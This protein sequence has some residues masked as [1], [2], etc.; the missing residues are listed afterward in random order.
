M[1][2]IRNILYSIEKY[3]YVRIQ[4]TFIKKYKIQTVINSVFIKDFALLL[5]YGV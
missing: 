5:T 1:Y 2:T 3:Q 4:W